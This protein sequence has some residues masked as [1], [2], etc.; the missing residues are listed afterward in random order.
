MKKY[1]GSK[2]E[3]ERERCFGT[4]SILLMRAYFFIGF[5]DEIDVS[6]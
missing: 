1:R 4:L 6:F 3:K 2:I 5:G